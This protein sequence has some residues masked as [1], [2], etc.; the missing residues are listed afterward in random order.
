M[1]GQIS[2]HFQLF[3][4]KW[5]VHLPI[6][7]LRQRNGSKSTDSHCSRESCSLDYPPHA[8]C[9]F[10]QDKGIGCL[11]SVICRGNTFL[12]FGLTNPLWVV[13]PTSQMSMYQPQFL[14][15]LLQAPEW[16]QTRTLFLASTLSQNCVLFCLQALWKFSPF[17]DDKLF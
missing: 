12:P 5:Q 8:Q 11:R 14:G 15:N 10:E 17:A 16:I 4:T 13:R 2:S 9:L 6:F 3:S 7:H 1:C